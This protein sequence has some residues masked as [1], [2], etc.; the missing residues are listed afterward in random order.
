MAYPLPS[1]LTNVTSTLQYT[2]TITNGWFGP[3]L[4]I[5]VGSIT[6]LAGK[7]FDNKRAFLA[8]AWVMAI[9][10]IFLRLMNLI[11]DKWVLLAVVAL[12]MT[13]IFL[14]ATEDN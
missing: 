7:N 14:K 13:L 12:G 3:V 6:F 5:V 9:T 10:S 8:S 4:L 11:S 2:S 1:N